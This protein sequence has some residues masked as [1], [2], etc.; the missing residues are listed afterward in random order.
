MIGLLE[1][2]VERAVSGLEQVKHLNLGI[3]RDQFDAVAQVASRRVVAIAEARCE[4]QDLLHSF[5]ARSQHAPGMWRSGYGKVK[6]Y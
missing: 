5:S 4:D 3:V 2:R 1:E 6:G